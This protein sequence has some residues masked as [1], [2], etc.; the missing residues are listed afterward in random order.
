M[1]D[2]GRWDICKGGGALS[3]VERRN[4]K[5]QKH[6]DCSRLWKSASD[7]WYVNSFRGW[8]G[9]VGSGLVSSLALAP[10]MKQNLFTWTPSVHKRFSFYYFY[11]SMIDIQ[12]YICFRSTT[13]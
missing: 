11:C 1:K 3:L 9:K 13:H 5:E 7:I 6:T 8:E 4:L 2:E 10:T 12:L